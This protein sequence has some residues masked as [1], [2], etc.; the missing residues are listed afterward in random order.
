MAV[1]GLGAAQ[2]V[3]IDSARRLSL[4]AWDDSVLCELG[5]TRR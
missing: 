2:R 1:S 4:V 5:G 3:G